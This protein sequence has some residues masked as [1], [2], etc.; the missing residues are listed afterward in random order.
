MSPVLE[1]YVILETG[2]P[3]R[4]HFTDHSLVRKMIRDP[5]TGQPSTR[6]TLVFL[7]DRLN[8]REVQSQYSIMAEKHAAQFEPY[9]KDKLYRSYEFIITKTGTEFLTLYSI[10]VVPTS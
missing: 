3:A 1:N 5:L 7:V 8:G 9:L 6:N 10:T 4:L 2:V